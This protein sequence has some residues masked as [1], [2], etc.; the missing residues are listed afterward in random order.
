M[1]N[2]DPV[3]YTSPDIHAADVTR[4][5][6][7]TWQL[8]GPAA[9]LAER[10][11]YIATEIAGQKVFVFMTKDGLRAYRNVCRHRGARLLP[12]GAG[13]CNTLRCPYHQ[14]VWGE[15]GSLLNVPWWGDDADF[16]KEDWALDTVEF[17]VWRGL[18][19]VAIDPAEPFDAQL[20][21][22]AAELADEPIESFTWVHEE[23]LVFDANWKIYTDNFVE[24]YH[25]P[26]IHPAFHGAIEFDKFETV[27][28]DGLVRMTAPPRDGL[29]YR[30]KWM[31]MWPNWTLSLFEGGMNTS[32]INPV[33]HERTELIYNFYFADTSEDG[34]EKRARTIADNLEVVR[35]DFEVCLETQKNY[36]SGGYRAGPLSPRHEQGVAYF[37]DRLRAAQG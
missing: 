5:F 20:G 32:R 21:A 13:R 26:G 35:E 9:R 17:H 11:D 33:T 6:A 34:A 7:R 14:W 8:I 23:R 31:W 30:G 27:A 29:F 16:R 2:L 22:T 4:I 19:F 36:A 25:I 15:D 12:E 18:L 3:H 28:L 24:G 37:Q 10:G 1:R